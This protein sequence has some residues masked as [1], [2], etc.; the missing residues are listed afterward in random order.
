MRAACEGAHTHYIHVHLTSLSSKNLTT[1]WN[2]HLTCYTWLMKISHR[3][4]LNTDGWTDGWMVGWLD[5]WMDE[6]LDGWIADCMDGGI[7]GWLDGRLDA[8]MAGWLAGWLD[9]WMDGWLELLDQP[10]QGFSPA[11]AADLANFLCCW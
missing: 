10:L 5:G 4:K 3:M 11:E 2:S 7:D 6:W 1:W 9:G 8:W